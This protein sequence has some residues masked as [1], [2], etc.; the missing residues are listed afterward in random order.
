MK[1]WYFMWLTHRMQKRDQLIEY[2]TVEYHCHDCE[3]DGLV[4]R[5]ISV[6]NVAFWFLLGIG[7]FF[8]FK[9]LLASWGYGLLVGFLVWFGSTYVNIQLVKPQCPHCLSTHITPP[10]TS[11]ELSEA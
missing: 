11:P 4:V 9:W 7:S 1:K 5:Q 10:A 2:K 6:L 8:L 3:K